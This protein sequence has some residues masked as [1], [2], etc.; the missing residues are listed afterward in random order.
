MNER[1][2]AVTK[3]RFEEVFG[4]RF[5]RVDHARDAT[6]YFLKAG[7]DWYIDA[8]LTIYNGQ[9][10]YSVPLNG[11]HSNWVIIWGPEVSDTMQ[12]CVTAD[13]VKA[14]LFATGWTSPWDWWGNCEKIAEQTAKNLQEHAPA[15]EFWFNS[16][17][18]ITPNAEFHRRDADESSNSDRLPQG[19]LF[20]TSDFADSCVTGIWMVA[21][22]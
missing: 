20:A 4:A 2:G 21:T 15:G 7:K 19:E 3:D 8:R 1:D 9:F 14:L 5:S 6:T 18:P 22:L 12:R 10:I 17:M 11:A 13:R 16:P